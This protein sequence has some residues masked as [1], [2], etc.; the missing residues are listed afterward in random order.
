MSKTLLTQPKS[1]K[2][3]ISQ[4]HVPFTNSLIKTVILTII[5]MI[6]ASFSIPTLYYLFAKPPQIAS[7]SLEK[8]QN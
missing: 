4:F 5:L 1:E 7:T 2:T 8:P 6:V 3:E